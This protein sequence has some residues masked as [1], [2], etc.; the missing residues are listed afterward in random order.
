MDISSSSVAVDAGTA[1]YNLSGWLGGWQ[2][3]ADRAAL[4]IG[5][6]GADGGRLGSA[7]IGA[8][9][10]T[11]R[12]SVTELLQRK[13]AGT[14]QRSLL[15]LSWDEAYD[16][17][18]GP[19]YP[20]HVATL[21]IGSQNTVKAGYTSATR[22]DHYSMLRTVDEALGLNPLTDNDKYAAPVN[23]VWNSG[24]SNP[25]G[26][27]VSAASRRCL[28]DPGANT[29]NGTRIDIWDRG[30]AANQRWTAPSRR[31]TR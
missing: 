18:Y 1:T 31:T 28:D 22:V 29:A 9:T 12:N 13:T 19:N 21:V 4:A 23:D 17:A 24:T 6:L 15:I 20:Y 26:P 14:Q 7:Q 2:A 8:V 25:T 10:W 11:D 30:G 5:L 3:D 16:K 27:L